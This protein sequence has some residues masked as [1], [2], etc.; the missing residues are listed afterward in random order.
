MVPGPLAYD[1]RRFP[2]MRLLPWLFPLVLLGCSKPQAGTL[3]EANDQPH[4]ATESP[5]EQLNRIP[6]PAAGR[7]PATSN[8]AANLADLGTRKAGSDWPAFLGPAGNGVSPEKGIRSPWPRDGLRVVW[9]REVET[10]YGMPSISRGRL[11]QFERPRREAF[12]VLFTRAAGFCASPLGQGPVLA[13][14]A[15]IPTGN[16]A[17]LLC[18]RS[19]TGESLWRFSYPTDYEDLYNYDNGPRCCPVID[20]DRVFLFGAEGMLHCVRTADGELVWKVDT[21]ADFGVVQNFFG[22]ASTP[23]VEGD[24]LIVQVGGSPPGSGEYPSPTLQGNQS[25]VVAFDKY[26]GKVKYRV[27]DELASYAGPVLA[28]VNGRRWCFVF[29]RGGLV[30]LE[31]ATGTVD[32]HYPWRARTLESVNASNPLVVGDR[33]FISECYGPGSSLLKVKPG[34]YEVLWTDADKRWKKSMQCHWS[35]PIHHD[36][37]LYGSSGRHAENAELRCIELA[38][39]KVT[40]SQPDLG[41]TTLLMVDGHFVCLTEDGQ[42]LLLKVNP[43]RYEEVSRIDLAAVGI[44]PPCWAAPIL[45]HGLLYVRGRNKLVCFE[46]IPAKN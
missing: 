34:G 45:S 2:A 35:T 32:F 17:C 40:W 23:V 12:P 6:A 30:G 13:A 18:L 16:E 31:P 38:T 14:A 19:E 43:N 25:G 22:V 28:T 5:R 10:G 42:L 26:T 9:Q 39:G 36:S 27:T 44:K 4:P 11:F 8:P 46:L 41:R 21:K 24:L 20:G 3:P 29:A 1:E 7:G 15:F 37:Y 33:V